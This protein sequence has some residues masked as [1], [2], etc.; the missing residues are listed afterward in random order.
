MP[1]IP[2]VERGSGGPARSS[3]QPPKA[4]ARRARLE[5]AGPPDHHRPRNGGAA[6]V[7]GRSRLRRA[8]GSLRGRR[9][10][11]QHGFREGPTSRCPERGH[12]R[13][14]RN[15]GGGIVEPRPG[16][17]GLPLTDRREAALSV[18]AP[19]GTRYC[20]ATCGAGRPPACGRRRL[21]P[22]A[23]RS[24]GPGPAPRSSARMAW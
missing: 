16:R 3:P 15:G 20:H 22:C 2:M 14:R 12:R 7:A 10:P 18:P 13:A 21:W 9:Y 24:A 5:G 19:S 1:F 6:A 17:D 4:V 11:P 8:H 23:R